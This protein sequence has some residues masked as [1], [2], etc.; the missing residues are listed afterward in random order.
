[1]NLMLET[2]KKLNYPYSWTDLL[3]TDESVG[4]FGTTPEKALLILLDDAPNE[5][6]KRNIVSDFVNIV[7]NN[8]KINEGIEKHYV[9]E[10]E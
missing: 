7:I 5:E 4:M 3:C 2:K 10:N 8:N 6:T 9:S 1:M